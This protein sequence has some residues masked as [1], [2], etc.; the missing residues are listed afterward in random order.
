[1]GKKTKLDKGR[2]VILSTTRSAGVY[3]VAL[4]VGSEEML[5]RNAQKPAATPNLRN[6]LAD[7]FCEITSQMRLEASSLQ[8]SVLHKSRMMGI[9]NFFSKVAGKIQL[10]AQNYEENQR[11]RVGHLRVIVTENSVIAPVVGTIVPFH[12]AWTSAGFDTSSLDL[13]NLP[14]FVKSRDKKMLKLIFDTPGGYVEGVPEAASSLFQMREWGNIT[15]Y[16]NNAN[17]AGAYL[18]SQAD[19]IIVKPSGTVGSIG[20]RTMHISVV[21]AMEK[22]GINITEIATPDKKI[23]LSP[24]K[25]LTEEAVSHVQGHVDVLF[26]DFL[27]A[28]ARGRGLDKE[29][30][31]KNSCEGRVVTAQDALESGMIDTILPVSQWEL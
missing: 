14:G 27:F 8:S 12:D 1:M 9:A 10:Q 26:E 6:D 31:R 11:E 25:E 21:G 30:V 29:Y 13:E 4:R 28:V 16:V 15:S 17:S 22:A 2:I 19:E 5:V 23:E 24:Y 7:L 18:A 3:P 20:V